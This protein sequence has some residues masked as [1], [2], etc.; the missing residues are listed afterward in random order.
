MEIKPPEQEEITFV[1][2]LLYSALAGVGGVLAY[3]VRTLNK[4]ERPVWYRAVLE[5][6]SSG[7]VGL[8]AMLLCKALNLDWQ[9]SGVIVGVFGWLG[10]ET[11]IVLLSNFIRE[12]I[13][14]GVKDDSSRQE[15]GKKSD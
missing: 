3:M 10:A 1:E 7:F 5:M 6:F 4:G 15:T 11:S 9:W 8:L 13:G 14:I 2:T 12:R